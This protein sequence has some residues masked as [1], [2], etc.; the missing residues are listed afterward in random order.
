MN[1]QQVPERPFKATLNWI[2]DSKRSGIHMIRSTTGE[3]LKALIDKKD[4]KIIDHAV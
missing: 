3:N 1:T 4:V 2:I